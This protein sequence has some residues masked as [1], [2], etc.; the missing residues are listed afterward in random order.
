[1]QSKPWSLDGKRKFIWTFIEDRHFLFE[2]TTT[3]SSDSSRPISS[4]KQSALSSLPASGVR[5]HTLSVSVR[6]PAE[7][8]LI[9]PDAVARLSALVRAA[10]MCTSVSTPPKDAQSSTEHRHVEGW[11]HYYEYFHKLNADMQVP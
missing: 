11:A 8:L 7:C 9:N 6:G 3:I 1:M 4:L 10:Q 5:G 2:G